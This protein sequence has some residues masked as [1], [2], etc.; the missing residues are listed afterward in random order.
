MEKQTIDAT[1]DKCHH[2]GLDRITPEDAGVHCYKCPGCGHLL[3]FRERKRWEN[4]R[5]DD[6]YEK[7]LIRMNQVWKET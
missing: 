5:R 7:E 4:A 3:D 2:R 6:Y 1:C